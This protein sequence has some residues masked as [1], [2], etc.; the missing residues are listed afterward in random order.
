[1]AM[2]GH[3]LLF[4]RLLTT[5]VRCAVLLNSGYG[6]WGAAVSWDV[7]PPSPVAVVQTPP[8]TEEPS[9]TVSAT[10]S[11][12][13]GFADNSASPIQPVEP[14]QALA[15][16]QSVAIVS[17]SSAVADSPSTSVVVEQKATV[18]ETSAPALDLSSSAAASAD[19]PA[20]VLGSATDASLP[21]AAISTESEVSAPVDPVT[22]PSVYFQNSGSAVSSA[23]LAR[24]SEL[25][26]NDEY[27]TKAHVDVPTEAS[28]LASTSAA[29]QH[30]NDQRPVE[31]AVDIQDS[32]PLLSVS[33]LN[34]ISEPTLHDHHASSPASQP[35]QI[36][37]SIVNEHVVLN[38]E[39]SNPVD[40][41]AVVNA[42]QPLVPIPDALGANDAIVSQKPIQIAPTASKSKSSAFCCGDNEDFVEPIKSTLPSASHST[43][44]PHSAN[45]SVQ[46]EAHATEPVVV[47]SEAN[48]AV[49]AQTE[50][51][52]EVLAK[53]DESHDAPCAKAS[54]VVSEAVTTSDS[55]PSAVVVAAAAEVLAP[56]AAIA[57]CTS[58]LPVSGPVDNL[59]ASA[60]T[61]THVLV[62]S[63]APA[64]S[65]INESLPVAE[66]QTIAVVA[67]V[68]P[69][70]AIN[71]SQ[72]PSQPS[73]PKAKS[74]AFCCGSDDDVVEPIQ[75]TAVPAPPVAAEVAAEADAAKARAE[76]KAAAD[77]KAQQ[78]REALAKIDETHDAHAQHPF[79]S[80]V[81]KANAK[82]AKSSLVAVPAAET[83]VVVVST[84]T[85]SL[86]LPS[87]AVEIAT[88]PA[89]ALPTSTASLDTS[90]AV[91]SIAA[92]A[93]VVV[94]D[95]LVSEQGVSSVPPSLDASVPVT[96][97]HTSPVIAT[98]I[99]DPSNQ[100]QPVVLKSKPKSSAFCCGSDDDVTVPIQHASATEPAPSV[101]AL[102][103]AA[104]VEPE[105]DA[106][107]AAAAAEAKAAADAKAKQ[108]REALAKIDETHDAH[109][110]HPFASS[111]F[112][113]SAKRAKSSLGASEASAAAPNIQ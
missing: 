109:A 98:A 84:A 76:A 21:R 68:M 46:S 26:L 96:E 106:A 61:L 15:L 100:H 81:F 55:N 111:V 23:I 63:E 101:A 49:E 59:S 91:A 93:P 87:A 67:A 17:P 51:V 33:I 44:A 18:A 85:R 45:P 72:A 1:M 52:R 86:P 40:H 57:E 75:R 69:A 71:V 54:L 112:K 83:N 41:V 62:G 13:G 103:V 113:A 108:V 5:R 73:A 14:A 28:A 70:V 88:I 50:Q 56:T 9:A 32:T 22:R 89:T 42:E 11:Q 110:Q 19:T 12:P 53:I 7:A 97:A 105:A 6:T 104:E 65:A 2:Y 35:P 77:A 58:A 10:S 16:V 37:A 25:S 79:A 36:E 90:A 99:V 38:A 48:A 92:S 29:S 78:I 39:E 102:S 43:A 66:A 82:R 24:M 8:V 47:G 94:L 4:G 34:K 60:P 20:P 107:K 3:C 95:P 27:A 30:G 31:S 74:S 80:S 64:I